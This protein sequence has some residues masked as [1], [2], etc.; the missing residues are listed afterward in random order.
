MPPTSSSASAG[1]T[2]TPRPTARFAPTERSAPRNLGFEL[3]GAPP[4]CE[5]GIQRTTKHGRPDGRTRLKEQETHHVPE[6]GQ[7]AL[8]ARRRGARRGRDVPAGPRGR[9]PPPP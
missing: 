8:A 9:R 5:R 7:H 4:R 6:E 3:S 2:C 1:G